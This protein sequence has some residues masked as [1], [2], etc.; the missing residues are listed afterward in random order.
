MG[1]RF[2]LEGA[3]KEAMGAET[4]VE[5]RCGT[6]LHVWSEVNGKKGKVE[7]L[8]GYFNCPSCCS[9]MCCQASINVTANNAKAIEGGGAPESADMER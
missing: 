5:H 4:K 6:P 2:L 9:P 7:C 3:I 1:N 8:P